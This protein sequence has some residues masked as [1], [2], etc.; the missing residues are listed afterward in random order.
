MKKIL[1]LLIAITVFLSLAGCGKKIILHCDN[2]N[3]EISVKEKDNMDEDWII[4]CHEC[5]EKL[6]ANDPAFQYDNP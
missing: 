6:F 4:Y 2:C 3:K 1:C 5:E